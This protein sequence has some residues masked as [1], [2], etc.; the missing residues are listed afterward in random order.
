[1]RKI[2]AA[3]ALAAAAACAYSQVQMSQ[4]ASAFKDFASDMAGSLAVS[5][6]MGADWSDAYI[7][8]FPHLGL[9]VTVGGTAVNSGVSSKLFSSM[10]AEAPSFVSQVGIPIPAAVATFKIGVPFIPV[11]LGFKIG[12]LPPSVDKSLLG[13]SDGNLKYMNWG[14]QARYALIKQSPGLKPNVSVGL[15]FNHIDGSVTVPTGMSS[16]TYDLDGYY[17]TADSPTMDLSWQSNTVDITAQISKKLLIFVPYAGA[18]LTLGK[19][20]VTG[21]V[22]SDI[23]TNYPGGVSALKNYLEELGYSVPDYMTPSGFSYT[24]NEVAPLFR[25]YG[26]MS[27]RIVILDLDLQALYL[28]QTKSVGASFTGRLQF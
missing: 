11:D 8:G 13:S 21:G 26:G 22:D 12:F 3:F 24:E 5:S 4:F 23:T 18:G 15:A 17:I 25:V 9:G 19:A 10:G 6:T 14:L 20:S 7:G 27:F 2:L 28:P 16:Q 1:M